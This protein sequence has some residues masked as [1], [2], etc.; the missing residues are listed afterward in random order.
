MARRHAGAGGSGDGGLAPHLPGSEPLFSRWHSFAQTALSDASSSDGVLPQC[1]GECRGP[2]PAAGHR[3]AVS[4]SAG[5]ADVLPT[6]PGGEGAEDKSP[7]ARCQPAEL[8]AP[9]CGAQLAICSAADSWPAAR[10]AGQL[11]LGAGNAATCSPPFQLQTRDRRSKCSSRR[12][13]PSRAQAPSPTTNPLR[14]PAMQHQRRSSPCPSSS[15]PCARGH[16]SFWCASPAG[17]RPQPTAA[18][19]RSDWSRQCSRTSGLRATLL[20]RCQEEPPRGAGAL[21]FPPLTPHHPS[22]YQTG[23]RVLRAPGLLW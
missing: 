1:T 22:P 4:D 15:L 17:P 16:P 7:M 12:A 19:T 11:K 21:P 3:P 8:P 23:Q 18:P 5:A 20:G 2:Q 14:R 10:R 9:A 6:E 13:A